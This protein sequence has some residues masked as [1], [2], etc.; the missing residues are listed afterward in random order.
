MYLARKKLSVARGRAPR[1]YARPTTTR[2]AARAGS[3]RP[4]VCECAQRESFFPCPLFARGSDELLVGK[5]AKI[6]LAGV[7]QGAG[8]CGI[9]GAGTW[10]TRISEGGSVEFIGEWPFSRGR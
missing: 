10:R 2:I 1:K 8:K 3:V 5:S 4:S 9:G 6:G 7:G